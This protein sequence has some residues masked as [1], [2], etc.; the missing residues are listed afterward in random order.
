MAM[1]STEFDIQPGSTAWFVCRAKGLASDV[2]LRLKAVR[3]SDQQLAA[4]GR[5]KAA[6][7]FKRMHDLHPCTKVDV[8]Y[9]FVEGPEVSA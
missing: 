9:M 3:S 1:S 4:G 2:N 8:E 5:I 6:R 7:A